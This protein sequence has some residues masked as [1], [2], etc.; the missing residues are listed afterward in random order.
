MILIRNLLIRHYR[1]EIEPIGD[2]PQ[3]DPNGTADISA[4]V[5][6]QQLDYSITADDFVRERPN[7]TAI[8][9][10]RKSF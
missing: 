3:Y 2:G 6:N 7:K 10:G 4:N 8:A 5:H 1:E 9:T